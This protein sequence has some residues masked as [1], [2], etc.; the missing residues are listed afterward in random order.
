MLYAVLELAALLRRHQ[1]KVAVVTT[2][3]PGATAEEVE[4]EVTDRIEKAI[5]EMPQVKELDSFSRAGMS[6]VKVIIH[7]YIASEDL[8]QIWDELRK[9]IGDVTGSLPPGVNR[10]IVGDD[11][12]DVYGF[13]M[14]VAPNLR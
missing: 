12:G 11:F 5:Q 4:L 9:K 2:I 3:Y 13:L 8:P 6:L 10:P 1:V 14:A 7:P